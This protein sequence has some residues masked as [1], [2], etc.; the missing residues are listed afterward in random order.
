MIL[1]FGVP[2]DAAADTV[3][4]GDDG[5]AFY[6]IVVPDGWN[7]DL[8]VW[9][10]GFSLSPV[11]PVS[12]LGPLAPLQLAEGYAVAASSFQMPGWAVFKTNEDLQTL[13]EA[14]VARF[15]VPQRVLVTG[16]SLGGIVSAAALEGADVGN[17]AGAL[18]LCGA[19]AGSRNWDAALDLRLAYDAMCGSVPGAF[20]PGGAEGLPGGSSL[21]GTQ[22][23]LAVNACFGILAPPPAR[24]PAQQARLA[25]FQGLFQL[26]ENFVL[27][28]MGYATFAMSDLVHDHRKLKGRIGVGNENVVYGDPVTDAQIERVSPHQGAAHR[29]QE[30]YTPTGNVGNVKIVSLH[31]DK[32]GLVSVENESEYAS[33][34][35]A[36]NLTTAVV[37]EAVPSHCGFTPAEAVAGWEALRGWVAGGPQPTAAAIQGLCA[38]LAPSVGGPCR[39]DP[40]FVIPDMDGRIRP[41]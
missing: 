35:P 17:V 3:L 37:V 36:S 24:T 33:V 5:Q 30:D 2:G 34:V 25:A 22:V 6:K 7:G 13:Y 31:T 29:L 41:R 19:L 9:N 23:A 27:T 8:V 20:L 26:P 18:T 1:G 21:T 10:H 38:A 32:D 15:G 12:D 11:G 4:A 14:F 28:D 16:A 40:T 39:I